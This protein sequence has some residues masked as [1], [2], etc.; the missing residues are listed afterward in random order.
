MFVSPFFPPSTTNS[1]FQQAITHYYLAYTINITVYQYYSI[2]EPFGIII[3]GRLPLANFNEVGDGKW[4]ADIGAVP[5][6]MVT[7]LTG[8][9]P[10]PDGTVL[11]VFMGTSS[12]DMASRMAMG[13]NQQQ[14][15]QQDFLYLGCVTNNSP[16]VILRTPMA[17]LAANQE[18]CG[19]QGQLGATIGLSIEPI[20]TAENLGATFSVHSDQFRAG[21]LQ[22]IAGRI[23]GDLVRFVTSYAKVLSSD[24]NDPMSEE[25]V[26]LPASWVQRWEARF[27]SRLSK[28]VS[29]LNSEE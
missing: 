6:Q 2:M 17:I 9:Q 13:G 11:A 20:S 7:F 5:E 28:D 8:S 29:Y 18:G 14:S 23:T 4:S 21:T 27:M 25:T 10:L 1:K 19:W 15:Q 16:S 26:Y 24:P 22:R 12:V 3:P